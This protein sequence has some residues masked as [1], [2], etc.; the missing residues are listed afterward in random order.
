MINRNNT[1][2]YIQYRRRE[3]YVLHKMRETLVTPHLFSVTVFFFSSSIK[4]DRRATEYVTPQQ[5]W[6]SRVFFDPSQVKSF[7][8]RTQ[9]KSSQVVGKKMFLMTSQSQVIQSRCK[10]SSQSKSSLPLTK[11]SQ[12]KSQVIDL[13]FFKFHNLLMYQ[14][15]EKNYISP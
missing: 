10:I 15:I 1:I 8:K 12:V 14:F 11:S 6:A 3:Y 5:R 9:V 13:I 4:F 2:N 7:V